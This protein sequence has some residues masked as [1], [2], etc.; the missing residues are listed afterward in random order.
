MASETP[1]EAPPDD[2]HNANVPQDLFTSDEQSLDAALL[3]AFTNGD[4]GNTS[5]TEAPQV[6]NKFAAQ[7]SMPS[8]EHGLDES[9]PNSDAPALGA[10]EIN[11]NSFNDA[12]MA[13]MPMLTSSFEPNPTLGALKDHSNDPILF[14]ADDWEG[15]SPV[16]RPSSAIAA[17][18]TVITLAS[19][20]QPTLEPVYDQVHQTPQI[21]PPREPPMP[22]QSHHHFPVAMNPHIVDLRTG[23]RRSQSVPPSGELTFHRNLATGTKCDIGERKPPPSTPHILRP[24]QIQ[25]TSA[26]SAP[27]GPSTFAPARGRLSQKPYYHGT[28]A[29]HPPFHSQPLGMRTE[30]ATPAP[31]TTM[32]LPAYPHHASAGGG[33]YKRP[34]QPCD[35]DSDRDRAHKPEAKR[36]ARKKT[37]SP[38]GVRAADLWSVDAILENM[39]ALIGQ[40]LEQVRNGARGDVE[41]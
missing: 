24:N 20:F 16:A 31:Y 6:N 41:L 21:R 26:S 11:A 33:G 28:S 5:K 14:S 4:F 22:P 1:A 23:R 17:S 32:T 27:F 12:R 34:F 8:I 2:S 25:C 7:M 10:T 13:D 29:A 18:N 3:A 40:R 37:Q 38:P 9:Q 36:R 19:P 39:K 35:E 30:P 15:L